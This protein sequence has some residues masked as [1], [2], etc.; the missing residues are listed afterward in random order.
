MFKKYFAKPSRIYFHFLK[1][2]PLVHKVVRFRVDA[3]HILGC[4]LLD[5]I[6][7]KIEF[8]YISNTNGFYDVT[9]SFL[10]ALACLERI[11]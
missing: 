3:I 2:D 11:E 4:T 6:R 5:R 9:I 7:E 10:G 8:S 1:K